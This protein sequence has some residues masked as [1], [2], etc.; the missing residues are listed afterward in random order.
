MALIIPAGAAQAPNGFEYDQKISII[1]TNDQHGIVDGEQ[2]VKGLA[3]KRKAAGEYVLTVNAGDVTQGE[4]IN[5]LTGGE[6]VVRIMNS[7]C[8]DV[9][10]PGNVEFIPDEERFLKL[11]PLIAFPVIAANYFDNDGNRVFDPYIIKEFGGIKIGIFG[12]AA[13][14]ES[15]YYEIGKD[16]VAELKSKGCDVIIALVHLGVGAAYNPS[17][18]G[19]AENVAGIDVVVD[20]HSH[21][22]LEKGISVRDTLVAQAGEKLNYIGITELYIKSEKI[23]DKRA[24]LIDRATYTSTI[25]PDASVAAIIAEELAAVNKVTSS[26]IGKTSHL[27]DGERKSVRTSETNLGDMI[28]D[29]MR[30][31]TNADLA[32][33]QGSMIRASIA[34]GDITTGSVLGVLPMGVIVTMIE[35]P[36]RFILDIL[37]DAV[38]SYPEQSPAFLQVSGLIYSFNPNGKPGKRV[39]EVIMDNGNPL[40]PEARY[41]VVMPD[42]L[43]EDMQKLDYGETVIG[44][45]GDYSSIFIDYIKSNCAIPKDAAGRIKIRQ[46]DNQERSQ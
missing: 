2:Y 34:A 3:D 6:G 22:V 23:I 5:V 14:S 33:L 40:N 24:S 46:G 12:L 4:P 32:I 30:R 11:Q 38:K 9:F 25:K 45:Y 29:S 27:L 20:G 36:G 41:K 39:I 13:L 17:G 37:E 16:C 28:V 42:K 31:K 10:V 44:E 1:H 18:T 15:P 26:V 43:V 7:V 19:L 8:Y 35:A 21:T